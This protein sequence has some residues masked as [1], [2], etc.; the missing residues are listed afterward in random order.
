MLEEDYTSM[1]TATLMYATREKALVDELTRLK[2]Q[3]EQWPARRLMFT[4]W[5]PL[6]FMY[7]DNLPSADANFP[8]IDWNARPEDE[9]QW[10]TAVSCRVIHPPAVPGL[11]WPCVPDFIKDGSMCPICSNPWGPEGGW[12]IGSCGHMV[13]PNCLVHVILNSRRCPQCKTPLHRRLYEQ[14]GVQWGMPPDFE[15]NITHGMK[16]VEYGDP[17]L[18]MV[19]GHGC[20]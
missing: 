10:K 3:G 11:L 13:H 5:P 14:F 8:S 6:D 12:I 16:E 19:G 4:S 18:P 9:F 20:T 7:P 1:V 17:P 2:D 15:Y